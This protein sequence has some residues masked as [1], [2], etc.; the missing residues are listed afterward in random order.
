[1]FLKLILYLGIVHLVFSQT[2]ET[3]DNS[4]VEGCSNH[5]TLEDTSLTCWNRTLQFYEKILLS[6]AVSYIAVQLKIDQWRKRH[7]KNYATNFT[8]LREEAVRGLR[9]SLENEDILS[10][11]TVSS[12]VTA[13]MDRIEAQHHSPQMLALHFQCPLPCEYRSNMWRNIFIASLIVN[14]GLLLA[15]SPFICSAIRTDSHG[16]PLY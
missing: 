16:V 7:T 9:S 12:I 2:Y 14:I 8:F 4:T 11:A 3:G 13:L 1:M 10:A 15:V 5:C 6:H